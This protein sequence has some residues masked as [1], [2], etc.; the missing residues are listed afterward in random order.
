MTRQLVATLIY[1]LLGMGYVV[2]GIMSNSVLDLVIG[3][4]FLYVFNDRYEKLGRA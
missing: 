3:L 1:L 4:M 2:A